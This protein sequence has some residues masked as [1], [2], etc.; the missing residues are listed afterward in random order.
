[1][2][3]WQ[4]K[5]IQGTSTGAPRLVPAVSGE[6][7]VYVLGSGSSYCGQTELG[8]LSQKPDSVII[9]A[10]NGGACNNV[11]TGTLAIT[12]RHELA[13]VLGWSNQHGGGN[14]RTALTADCT[15]FLPRAG[16]EG[17]F[18]PTGVCYHEVEPIFRAYTQES[19]ETF[20]YSTPIIY[21]TDVYPKLID[22]LAPQATRQLNVSAWRWNDPSSSA[23]SRGWTDHSVSTSSASIATISSTGLV[24]GVGSG[25]AIIWLSP[26]NPT[27]PAG[28]TFWT[29]FRDRGDSV[30]VVVMPPTPLPLQ[31]TAITFMQ[32]P[33][34]TPGDHVATAVL[35]DP[36]S[37]A[38]VAWRVVSSLAQ[39]DTVR[40]TGSTVTVTVPADASY[41]ITF[42]ASA[43]GFHTYQ[44]LP[45]CTQQGGGEQCAVWGR[46]PSRVVAPR[47]RWA[48]AEPQVPA[49]GS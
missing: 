23:P 38:T 33:A 36:S 46:V 49:P 1:M 22:S 37:S 24:T 21:E 26:S 16:V 8:G 30:K 25:T 14:A 47:T 10:A 44:D 34:T 45:I 32:S 7:T 29:P 4:A 41:R 11:N 20:F 42:I 31:V 35:S 48:D 9:R 12:I 27:P 3:P 17:S 40:S 6:V 2:F 18:I 43:N 15:T 19:L 28:A 13:H 39:A 5:L